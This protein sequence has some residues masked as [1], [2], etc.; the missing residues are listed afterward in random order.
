M[1]CTCIEVHFLFICCL[2]VYVTRSG[3]WI[4]KTTAGGP[5]S[6]QCLYPLLLHMYYWIHIYSM[7]YRIVVCLC[8]LI[9][10]PIHVL[11][12]CA[13]VPVFLY[14]F[15]P[16]TQRSQMVERI[17]S[18]SCLCMREIFPEIWETMLFCVLGL[19]ISVLFWYSS[20]C[21]DEFSSASVLRMIYTSEGDSDW[22]P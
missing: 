19:R 14:L 7:Y 20:A 4:K 10:V 11:Y 5:A 8:M 13:L 16:C 6:C 1:Q 17:S 21:D 15:K 12:I 3:E 22:K 2:L 18:F 9:P